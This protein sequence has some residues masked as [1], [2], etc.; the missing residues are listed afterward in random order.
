MLVQTDT[1][2]LVAQGEY[3][4]DGRDLRFLDGTNELAYWIE[5]GVGT[6]TNRIWVKLPVLTSANT[7]I[8]MLYGNTNAVPASDGDKTF[9]FFDAFTNNVLNPAK[10][11]SANATVNAGIVTLQNGG[12][13]L[14]SVPEFDQTLGVIADYVF[15]KSSSGANDY[16]TIGFADG[17]DDVS[18][19]GFSW[20]NHALLGANFIAFNSDKGVT[21]WIDTGIP[22][23]NATNRYS[24]LYTAT[25]NRMDINDGQWSWAVTGAA[26]WTENFAIG[27]RS[28]APGPL[29]LH[30]IQ[31]RKA[32][33]Q[34]QFAAWDW[35]TKR[36]T[37][38]AMGFGIWM[39]LR[40]GQTRSK[41]TQMM[42]VF[43]INGRWTMARSQLWR[44]LP[45]IWTAMG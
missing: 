32:M 42:T 37:R 11:T 7:L 45:A 33:S 36:L 3:R 6:I 10:W 23:N 38:T 12:A 29:R 24:Q 17:Y 39:S 2:Q 19:A 35:R 30:G 8:T 13:F 31:I 16:Y 34:P 18:G 4:S 15:S 22:I 28:D 1:A 21:G 9:I 44:M 26:S 25:K 14:R 27:F 5:S 40:Q 41:P 20:Y 43:L